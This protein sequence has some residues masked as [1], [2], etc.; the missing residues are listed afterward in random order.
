MGSKVL[1]VRYLITK[2]KPGRHAVAL[3]VAGH[4]SQVPVPGSFLLVVRVCKGNHGPSP[5]SEH[6]L[7]LTFLSPPSKP[8][9]TPYSLNLTV[10]HVVQHKVLPGTTSCISNI[11]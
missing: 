1:K 5:T 9:E 2:Y 11:F 6:F 7:L 4:G 10:F 8:Q 3:S